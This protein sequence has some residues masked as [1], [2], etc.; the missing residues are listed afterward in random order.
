M[1]EQRHAGDAVEIW[2]LIC[3]FPYDEDLSPIAQF[4]HAYWGFHSAEEAVR[5]RRAEDLCAAEIVEASTVH[6]DYPD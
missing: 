1:Y 2:T 3:G 6:F 5:T 4:L